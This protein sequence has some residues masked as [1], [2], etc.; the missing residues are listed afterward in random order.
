MA[1]KRTVASKTKPKAKKGAPKAPPKRAAAQT[2]SQRELAKL[3]SI[4]PRK[5]ANYIDNN[6][7]MD[8]SQAGVEK[9]GL[10]MVLGYDHPLATYI[11]MPVYRGP[12]FDSK[13]DPVP[14]VTVLDL[15]GLRSAVKK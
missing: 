7:L 3:L 6:A 10:R 4:T 2:Y 11:S 9:P 15:E 8:A 1:A 5:L 12:G 13:N 14:E